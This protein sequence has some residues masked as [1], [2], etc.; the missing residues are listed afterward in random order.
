MIDRLLLLLPA[1]G[2]GL[3]MATCMYQIGK[4]KRSSQ[5]QPPTMADPGGE[6]AK[7]REEVARLQA[8]REGD[9]AHG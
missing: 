2:C 9:Q 5:P 1:L 7:L 8:Q 4:G 3:M 6:V